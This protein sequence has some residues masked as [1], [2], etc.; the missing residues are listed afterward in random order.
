MNVLPS[1]RRHRPGPCCVSIFVKKITFRKKLEALR[2]QAEAL[3]AGATSIEAREA[4]RRVEA[5][6]RD[7]RL[8][9]L[10]EATSEVRDGTF[11]FPLFVEAVQRLEEILSKESRSR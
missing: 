8:N 7:P 2:R 6:L 3:V 9:A 11:S 10:T 5:Y 4:A 1:P